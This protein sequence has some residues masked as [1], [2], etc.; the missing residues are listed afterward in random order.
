MGNGFVAGRL[1]AAGERFG[2]TYGA[3]LHAGILAWGAASKNFAAEVAVC[4]ALGEA[5]LYV[6]T[7]LI[8]Q[9][10]ATLRNFLRTLTYYLMQE[11][12]Y[13]STRHRPSNC[14]ESRNVTRR[15]FC[16]YAIAGSTAG[17]SRACA[18]RFA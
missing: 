14:S 6:C 18:R 15:A 12:L 16:I 10:L 8:A 3:L 7:V 11:K 1:N 2:W 17:T 4:T 13:V 5:D 9:Q